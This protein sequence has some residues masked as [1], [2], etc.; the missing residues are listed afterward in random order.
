MFRRRRNS[1][2]VAGRPGRRRTE[3]LRV[4][5][6]SARSGQRRVAG[7]APDR[8]S[9]EFLL[10][11]RTGSRRRLCGVEPAAGSDGLTSPEQASR[12]HGSAGT[13]TSPVSAPPQQDRATDRRDRIAGIQRPAGTRRERLRCS[14]MS[15]SI[16]GS[17]AGPAASPFRKAG[18]AL[19]EPTGRVVVA[20]RAGP[21]CA[22]I[23]SVRT[24]RCAGARRRTRNG[25]RRTG[26]VAGVEGCRRTSRELPAGGSVGS[27]V[28]P[29][30]P[31]RSSCRPRRA[32]ESVRYVDRI[33]PSIGRLV[34]RA[35]SAGHCGPGVESPDFFAIINMVVE[36]NRPARDGSGIRW[37][38]A[39]P[40][41]AGWG[42][43]GRRGRADG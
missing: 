39:G 15:R 31:E 30:V 16:P 4:C 14:P 43:R 23:S 32:T 29:E 34:E 35:H 33:R 38:R 5:G 22:A 21:P 17:A 9:A 1:G 26:C 27:G 36:S 25:I 24:S 28:G 3:A 42:R 10:G 37:V 40:G 6:R 20:G 2:V 41:G 18:S 12:V 8:L 7:T 19:F 11:G 13:A